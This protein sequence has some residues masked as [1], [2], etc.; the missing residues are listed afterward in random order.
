MRDDINWLKFVNTRRDPETGEYEV[1]YRPY[2][3]MVEGDRYHPG[4]KPHPKPN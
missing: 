4:A 2:E 1:L 3:Q